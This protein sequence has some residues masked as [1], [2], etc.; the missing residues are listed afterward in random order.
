M[1]QAISTV[2]HKHMPVVLSD[3][4]R[5]SVSIPTELYTDYVRR[6]G[7]D[8]L[9]FRTQLNEAALSA[10]PRLGVTRSLAVRLALDERIEQLK[11]A[12]AAA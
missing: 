10:K 2:A 3:G 4:T 6:M 5:T 7:G 1:N 12:A 9:A 8:P 11:T